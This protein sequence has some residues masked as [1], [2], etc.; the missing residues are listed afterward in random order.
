[1]LSESGG[2]TWPGELR[3]MDL[4]WTASITTAPKKSRWESRPAL[5]YV[6]QC[7][8]WQRAVALMG[9]RKSTS[10]IEPFD[11]GESDCDVDEAV[12]FEH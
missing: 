8:K 9:P 6:E 5:L 2:N 12:R 7:W 4:D 10:S 1:M 11:P 3:D